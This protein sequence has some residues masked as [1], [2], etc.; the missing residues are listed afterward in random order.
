MIHLYLQHV[1]FFLLVFQT[2]RFYQK[3]LNKTVNF[4][5]MICIVKL[6][7]ET[8]L[9]FG[10]TDKILHPLFS[11]SV[12]KI[13]P[14]KTRRIPTIVSLNQIKSSA[15]NTFE[16]TQSTYYRRF[17]NFRISLGKMQFL[18]YNGNI[19]FATCSDEHVL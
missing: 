2:T 9:I 16:M 6:I 11:L 19:F 17:T 7:F 3:V 12:K 10:V 1:Q 5:A 14:A 13:Y 15:M 18:L 8:F 4:V